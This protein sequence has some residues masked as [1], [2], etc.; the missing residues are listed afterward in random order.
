[1]SVVMQKLLEI[2]RKGVVSENDLDYFEEHIE[3]FPDKWGKLYLWSIQSKNYQL[4][5]YLL[6]SGLDLNTCEDV[7]R[8]VMKSYSLYGLY[9]EKIIQ[10]GFEITKDIYHLII[11]I[12]SKDQYFERDRIEKDFNYCTFRDRERKILK[13]KVRISRKI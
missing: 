4:S 10:D 12:Y 7:R 1:M 2:S 8:D 11:N 13:I 5:D 3:N 9:S 6:E